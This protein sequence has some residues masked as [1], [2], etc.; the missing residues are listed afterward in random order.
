M[1]GRILSSLLTVSMLLAIPASS[2]ATELP[3]SGYEPLMLA[4]RINSQALTQA[5]PVLRGT[6]GGWFLPVD[7]LRAANITLPDTPLRRFNDADYV[8]AQALGIRRLALDGAHQVLDIEFLP[9]QFRPTALWSRPM[10]ES[11]MPDAGSGAFL[12]YQLTF[13]HTPAGSGYSLFAEA[14]ATMAGGVG[15][16]SH[17]LIDRPGFGAETVRLETSYTRDDLP[18]MARLRLGDAITRPMTGLGRP[19]RFAGL[20][21][22]T[23]FLSRPGTVTVPLAT[24]SGQAALPSTADLYIDNVLQARRPISPG[25]FSITSAPL[26]TGEGEVLLKVTDLAGQEQIISQRFVT[27]TSML[28]A[29]LTDYSLAIGVL[30]RNFG[31]RND[32]YGDAFVAGG[33]RHGLS[34]RLTLEAGA[35]VQSDGQSEL[36]AGMASA[37]PGLGI[38]SAAVGMSR[39]VQGNGT[40]L[41]LGIERRTRDHSFSLRSQIASEDYRSIGVSAG[42]LPR[43]LDSLFYGY[44]V[45]QLGR[46]G[47]SFTRQQR[48]GDPVSIA[49]LSFSTRQTEWGSLILS[50]AQ[51]RTTTTE[52]ALSVFWVKSL[53]RDTSMSASHLQPAQGEAQH[54]LQLQQNMAPGEGWGYRLQAA[55]N[56]ATQASVFAQNGYGSGRLDIAELNGTTS[57]RAGLAGGLAWLDGQHFASRRIDSSFGVVSIPGFSNVRVYVDNQLAA[58]TDANGYALLPRLHPYMKNHVTVEPLDLPLD[59]Q[60]DVLKKQPVP[61]WRSGVRIDFPIRMSA[62]ATLDL[63]QLDGSPVPLGTLVRLDDGRSDNF[64]VGHDG[65]LYL[66]DLRPD[67]MLEA[68]WPGGRCQARVAYRPEPGSV[69]H[70]GRITCHKSD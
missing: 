1:C 50:V 41:A 52:H 15:I 2:G 45:G 25:P 22:G 24:L 17:G 36:Q 43:R 32:E 5:V 53:G 46:L 19:V 58:R 10:P 4:L 3:P 30:R 62:A 54:A 34:Q 12:N 42:Q 40:Q 21:W 28:A 67:T 20:Q 31:L 55:R 35:S 59:A 49:T 14:A 48:Q 16:S 37:V 51:N 9:E 8:D 57:L 60:V 64:V 65:V 69:P 39:S 47:V 44:R 26:V 70:L 18:R 23:N 38:L 7:L 61:A 29:G 68:V 33:W 63:V 66:S 27:S 6:D 11:G 56:A 13:D